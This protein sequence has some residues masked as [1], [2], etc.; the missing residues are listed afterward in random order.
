MRFDLQ[1][2]QMEFELTQNHLSVNIRK[3]LVRYLVQENN[4]HFVILFSKV[5]NT[6]LNNYMLHI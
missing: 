3:G 4:M 2:S 1:L 5:I 6:H